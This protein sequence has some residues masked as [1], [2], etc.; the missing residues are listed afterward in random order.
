[1]KS[2]YEF[3]M[4]AVLGITGYC[5]YSFFVNYKRLKPDAILE[6]VGV[7][8]IFVILCAIVLYLYHRWFLKDQKE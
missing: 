8:I 4:L 5:I 3:V 1:M 7:L 2:F 6:I